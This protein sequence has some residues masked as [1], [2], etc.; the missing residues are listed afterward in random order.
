M[1]I[2]LVNCEKQYWEFVRILRNDERVQDGFIE[3]INKLPRILNEYIGYYN[4]NLVV[5]YVIIVKNSYL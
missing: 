5:K 3:S 1:Q 4:Y 2:E